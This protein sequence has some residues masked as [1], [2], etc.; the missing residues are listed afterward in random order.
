MTP[1]LRVNW[2]DGVHPRNRSDV[3]WPSTHRRNANYAR[4]GGQ[5]R[6]QCQSA[7]DGVKSTCALGSINSPVYY[8][9]FWRACCQK[10]HRSGVA[11]DVPHH[12]LA[13][14]VSRLVAP[15]C[16]R[17]ANP[18]DGSQGSSEEQKT[19]CQP[20]AVCACP[21]HSSELPAVPFNDGRNA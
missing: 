14:S 18:R 5:S 7:V 2:A 4:T 21:R 3:P 20:C 17:W 6:T 10:C 1:L 11:S 16:T 9:A 13:S 15:P 12:S 8:W 19:H